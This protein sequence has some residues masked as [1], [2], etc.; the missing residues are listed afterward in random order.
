MAS[1]GEWVAG[2]CSAGKPL[3]EQ[4][5]MPQQSSIAVQ[6]D[7]LVVRMSGERPSSDVDAFDELSALWRQVAEECRC[8]G[9]A[10]VLFCSTVTGTGSSSVNFALFSNFG[11]FGFDPSARVAIVRT[12]ARVRRIMELGVGV[13]RSQGWR[14]ALFGETDAAR[15]WLDAT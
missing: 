4:Y 5:A 15:R 9:V 6:G 1:R 3:R 13:A 10:R 12:D 14:L 2:P 8:H 7:V 11:R